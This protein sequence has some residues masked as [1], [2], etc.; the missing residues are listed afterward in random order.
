[1]TPHPKSQV[2][3]TEILN[4]GAG[5]TVESAL[6][7]NQYSDVIGFI[8]VAD[9][10]FVNGWVYSADATAVAMVMVGGRIATPEELDL[11]RADVNEALGVTGSHG[12]SFSVTGMQI[13]ESVE[14]YVLTPRG[15]T[16]VA[17]SVVTGARIE[18]SFFSQL[19]MA[20][21][22]C[23]HHNAVAIACWDG[24]HNPVGRAKALYDVA[25]LKRPTLLVSY[26][27]ED[28]GGKIWAPLRETSV[29]ILT[30]PWRRREIYHRALATAS[31]KFNTVWICKPRLP[32]FLLTQQIAADGAKLIL[33]FDD[34]E[35]H[36]SRS[37]GSRE[38]PYG[39]TT[40]NL[41]QR[42]ASMIPAR[43]AAS[44]TL[45]TEMD[46]HL[47]RHARSQYAYEG[48]REDSTVLKIGFIGTVR[49]HKNILEAA[50]AVRLFAWKSGRNIEF[51]VY[52]DVKPEA[53]KND[54]E[55]NGAVV[56]Q[57]VAM[58]K[59]YD[60]LRTMDVVLTGYPSP[61]E[62][63][64]TR[65]QI[66]SKIGDALAVGR[67]VLVPL[68]P[69]TSDLKD[70]PGVYL[71]DES[72]FGGA[73]ALALDANEECHLPA[74]FTLE[75]AYES[76]QAAEDQADHERKADQALSSLAVVERHAI[77]EEKS[78]LLI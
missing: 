39:L 33:D 66:S 75:G 46:A 15:L 65:Y 64:I 59:L 67:P 25:Q 30:I 37:P 7:N 57:H 58:S 1:M 32:S 54:L 8:E 68:S 18:E 28:F 49:G 53:L 16:L 4:G 2:S 41:A 72:T 47:V 71:F 22:I 74:A 34:N 44:V 40:I 12:F 24:A 10:G 20:K 70:T 55:A 27:S 35:D 29:S 62:Q 56:I 51:H 26:L 17:S 19:A 9:G 63:E 38:K 11:Y 60:Q 45:T 31:I 5:E 76:F 42:L 69:S 13:G 52:G 50:R 78:L 3:E 21:A 48:R 61:K 6:P 36:F 43:T 77:D 73:L 23:A 14:L